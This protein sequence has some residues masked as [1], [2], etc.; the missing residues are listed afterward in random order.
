VENTTENLAIAENFTYFL[1]LQRKGRIMAVDNRLFDDLAKVAGGA[2]SLLSSV[3]KQIEA[4]TM[5][6]LNGFAGKLDLAERKE[7]D[8]LIAMV[9]QLRLEQEHIKLRLDA[10][11]G[12]KPASK[13]TVKTSV[14]KPTPKSKT[15]TAKKKK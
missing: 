12:K 11:E 13:K 5:T 1:I 10:L 8:R 14:K 7:L 2:V 3:R 6:H 4:D 9:G 15:T